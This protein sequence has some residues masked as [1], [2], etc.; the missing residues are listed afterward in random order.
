MG[1]LNR[2][3]P[4]SPIHT[5]GHEPYGDVPLRRLFV[6]EKEVST[7][8]NLVSSYG[9]AIFRGPVFV[10]RLFP[11][12]APELAAFLKRLDGLSAGAKKDAMEL[13]IYLGGQRPT[14][15]LRARASDLDLPAGTITLY[16]PKGRAQ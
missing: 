13:C 16:D 2:S 8:V 3:S 15:L 4:R 12:D 10:A 9:R 14:Q 6:D 5:A 1:W 11:R 7:L